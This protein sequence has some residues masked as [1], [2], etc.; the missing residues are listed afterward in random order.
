M[1][2][3]AATVMA[4]VLSLGLMFAYVL[5]VGHRLRL[6]ARVHT[7]TAVSPVPPTAAGTVAAELKPRVHVKV[8]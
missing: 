8:S 5:R 1:N 4:F 2:D 6:A 3:E 7:A